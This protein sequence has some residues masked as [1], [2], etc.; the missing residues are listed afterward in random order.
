MHCTGAFPNFNLAFFLDICQLPLGID[1]HPTQYMKIQSLESLSDIAPEQW[2][3]L[4]HDRH[5]FLRH[6]FLTAME[7]HRCVGPRTGW[8]PHHIVCFDEAD[9]LVGAAPLYL[10]T[11]SYGEFVFDWSWAEAYRRHGLAYYP[12]LVS[13]I[14]FTPAT[15]QRL[16]IAPGLNSGAVAASIIHYALEYIREEG[17]SS[18]HWLFTTDQDTELLR[19]QGL[20]KRLGCQFH[21][22]NRGFRDFQDFLDT[23]T[24]K[25]RKNINRERRHV[26]ETGLE[27]QLIKGTDASESQWQT[28]HTFYCSTFHRLGGFPTLTLPFFQEIASTMGDQIILVLACKG[29]QEVAGAVSFQSNNTLYGRH[30][31]CSINYDSLHFEACYY[32]GIDYCIGQGLQRFEP[33]AQG[34]HKISRGFLPTFIHSTHWLTHPGFREAVA[35]FLDRETPAVQDYARNLTQHSPYRAKAT[36]P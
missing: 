13:A 21:W 19:Q 2:N 36:H 17:L 30:W 26:Q 29:R 16:L 12:K 9:R 22:H 35:D 20:M 1:R 5:P 11:N 4:V 25:K 24:S 31:G 28:F 15:G 33:G 14:P 3:D 18:L 7:H 34:E 27:L 32:Q 6:E 10:K 8:L 23:L